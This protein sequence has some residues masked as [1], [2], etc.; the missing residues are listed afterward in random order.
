VAVRR[1]VTAS[2]PHSAPRTACS[3]VGPSPVPPCGAGSSRT[4]RPASPASTTVRMVASLRAV[5]VLR[6]RGLVPVLTSPFAIGH[7]HA[8]PEGLPAGLDRRRDRCPAHSTAAG[9]DRDTASHLADNAAPA[10][11]GAGRLALRGVLRVRTGS[12]WP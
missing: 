4:R 3:G 12:A 11:K 2:Q 9:R 1:N 10:A 8:A 7:L 6:R 5:S